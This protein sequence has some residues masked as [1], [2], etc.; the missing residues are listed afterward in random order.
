MPRRTTPATSSSDTRTL[1][2]EKSNGDQFKIEIPA[3]F[4]VTFGST[5]GNRGFGDKELRIYEAESKQRACF[6]G[7]A[8]FRDLGLPLTRLVVS[9]TGETH[10]DDD[11]DG[12]STRS[13]TRR[14]TVR[15][16]VA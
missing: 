16:V 7:V 15:E 14:R 4:K 11:G 8:S 3:D 2:V 12:L 13:T 1:L 10:W 6:V 9:E 5:G